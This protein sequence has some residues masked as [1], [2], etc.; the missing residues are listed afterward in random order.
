MQQILNKQEET[1][2]VRER[3][4]KHVPAETVSI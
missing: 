4:G 3:L 2:A 1:A